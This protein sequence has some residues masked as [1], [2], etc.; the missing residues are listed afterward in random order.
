M[1]R[2]EGVRGVE[3]LGDEKQEGRA[4]NKNAIFASGREIDNEADKSH[5]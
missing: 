3:D 5:S 1:S 2:G 4:L